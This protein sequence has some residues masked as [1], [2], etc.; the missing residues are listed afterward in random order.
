MQVVAPG[1]TAD[2]SKAQMSDAEW[3]QRCDL[4]VGC[5]RLR[6]RM[7]VNQAFGMLKQSS[8]GGEIAI[9]AINASLCQH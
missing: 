5:D 8:S 6:R 1:F 3:A 9:R 4:A 2:R 7:A